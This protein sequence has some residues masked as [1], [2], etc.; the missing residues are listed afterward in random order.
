MREWQRSEVCPKPTKTLKQKGVVVINLC[1]N[2]K[3]FPMEKTL[4]NQV[5]VVCFGTPSVVGD[6]F[7]PKVGTILKDDFNLPCF[8]YGSVDCPVTAKNKGEYIRLVS[9]VHKGATILSVDASLGQ[10]DKVGKYTIRNDGVCPA[11]IKG[12]KDRF[13]HV[14]ILGVVG[15]NGK[16][17]MLT[18]L[19]AN[20]DY[21]SKLAHK[22]AVVIKTAIDHV[23]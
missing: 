10:K 4:K 15:E 19:T 23:I 16:D 8:V 12:Q 22:V 5:V 17:N 9:M 6:S 7:G 14:G 2:G 21:V 13:G 3:D 20:D 18:L 11:G 1:Q